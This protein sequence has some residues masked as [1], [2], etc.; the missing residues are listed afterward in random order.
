[1][2]DAVGIIEQLIRGLSIVGNAITQGIKMLFGYV[3][4]TLPDYA[5]TLSTII[6]LI[7]ILYKFGNA[8]NKIILIALIFLLLSSCAGLFA[9]LFG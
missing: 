2:A 8:I 4:L 9:P 3:G 5:I 7:L 1:M 6:F